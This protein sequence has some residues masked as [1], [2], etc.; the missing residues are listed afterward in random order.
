MVSLDYLTATPGNG[1][2]LLAF[3][4]VLVAA[5]IVAVITSVIAHRPGLAAVRRRARG[6]RSI[7]RW[8]VVPGALYLIARYAKIDFFSLRIWLY[9]I[10][11]VF[12]ARLAWWTVGLRSLG[13]D[14]VDERNRHRK[15]LYFNRAK[16]RPAKRRRRR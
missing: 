10:L 7:C 2:Y 9:L 5:F 4:A 11:F 8:L 16:R 15:Q 6:L 1:P 12:A 13:V 3:E 14:K